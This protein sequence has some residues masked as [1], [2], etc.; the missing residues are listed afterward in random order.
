MHN[1]FHLAPFLETD[2]A[3][4]LPMIRDFCIEDGVPYEKSIPAL[5]REL[6]VS[7]QLG[8]VFMLRN[9]RATIGYAVL[10]WRFCLEYGGKI[11]HLDEFYLTPPARGHGAGAALIE[12]IASHC[13]TQGAHRILLDTVVVNSGA[14][15]FYR[16]VHFHSNERISQYLDLT[17]R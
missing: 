16:K 8:C 5:L 9:G 6:L 2:T 12:A 4:L 13:A 10:S 1:D 3:T 11:A 14:R 7:P 15:E 17:G